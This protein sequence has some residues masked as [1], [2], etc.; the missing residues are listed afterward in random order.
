M[1]IIR[2]ISL[3]TY[4]KRITVIISFLAATVLPA[5]ITG[6]TLADIPLTVRL[7]LALA[8]DIAAFVMLTL[9]FNMLTYAISNTFIDEVCT[10]EAF[11]TERNKVFHLLS[12]ISMTIKILFFSFMVFMSRGEEML[13]HISAFVIDACVWG[14]V[15]GGT[16]KRQISILVD[17]TDKK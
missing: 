5:Y 6:G 7:F 8:G 11:I 2:K 1:E 3:D 17:C 14:F 12:S 9:Y 13:V 15:S 4:C 16:V 10:L